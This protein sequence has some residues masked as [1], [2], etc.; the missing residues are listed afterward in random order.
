MMETNDV[1]FKMLKL[2]PKKFFYMMN[3]LLGFPFEIQNA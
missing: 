2:K 1:N 3:K